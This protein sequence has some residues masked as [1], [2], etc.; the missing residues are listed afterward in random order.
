MKIRLGP[1]PTDFQILDDEGNDLTSKLAV[2]QVTVVATASALKV[3]LEVDAEVEIECA[4]GKLVVG[5]GHYTSPLIPGGTLQQVV[6]DTKE[7]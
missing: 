1:L 7:S 5:E 6:G 2:Y 4:D 3:V